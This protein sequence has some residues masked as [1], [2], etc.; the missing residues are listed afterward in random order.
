MQ[1]IIIKIKMKSINKIHFAFTKFSCYR[2]P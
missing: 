1:I 2:L